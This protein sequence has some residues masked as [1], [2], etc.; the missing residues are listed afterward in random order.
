MNSISTART[1]HGPRRTLRASGFLGTLNIRDFLIR[2][3]GAARTGRLRL[4]AAVLIAVLQRL[5]SL[6]FFARAADTVLESNAG[7]LLKAAV[8]AAASLGAVDSV[9]G[10]TVFTLST[11]IPGHPSPF[12]VTAGV[13]IPA[14]AF[15]FTSTPPTD[16]PPKS[17][18][19]TGSIPPLAPGGT[20]TAAFA[21]TPTGRTIL[22][23]GDST[24]YP[25]GE[26]LLWRDGKIVHL[27]VPPPETGSNFTNFGGLT[28]GGKVVV[29]FDNN[30]SYFHNP[31]GWFSLKAVLEG[32]GIDLSDW[33][34]FLSFGVSA[35]GRLVFGSGFNSTGSEGFV[36]K[37]PR[38]YLLNYGKPAR[39]ADLDDDGD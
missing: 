1:T 28:S 24:G 16:S 34:Y 20:W 26:F 25:H 18:T 32:A 15:S 36:A 14:V 10:A 31:Y 39:A 13:A 12:A 11:G 19:I 9:A 3:S 17:W 2:L 29:T 6:Q 21:I 37:F 4:P 38:G 8:A 5:P 30:S 35:D 7:M 27:G 22:G 23:S 33:T